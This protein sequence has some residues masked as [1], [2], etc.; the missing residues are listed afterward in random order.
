MRKKYGKKN[1]ETKELQE[2]EQKGRKK[3]G[4]IERNFSRGRN[5][6]RI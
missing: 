5:L 6:K 2:E 3:K 4:K 1:A